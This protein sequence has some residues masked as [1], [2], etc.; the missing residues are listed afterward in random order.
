MK[1]LLGIL[2]EGPPLSLFDVL[3]VTGGSSGILC[4]PCDLRLALLGGSFVFLDRVL[5][6]CSLPF[7]GAL[8]Y[9]RLAEFHVIQAKFY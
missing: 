6:F 3:F 8:I 7:S 5:P 1:V 2:S 4:S 9:I